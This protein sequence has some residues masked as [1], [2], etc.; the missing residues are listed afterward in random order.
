MISSKAAA[1]WAAGN[2]AFRLQDQLLSTYQIPF[3]ALAEADR[4]MGAPSG[5]KVDDPHNC[6]HISFVDDVFF[7]TFITAPNIIL[8]RRDDFSILHHFELALS[9]VANHRVHHLII[10]F[11]YSA[12]LDDYIAQLD[13]SKTWND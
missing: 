8:F 7:R 5:D 3:G 1:C 2:P 12:G 10:F 6:D 13:S 11:G 4:K 9:D